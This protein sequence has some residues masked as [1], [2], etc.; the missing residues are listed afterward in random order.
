MSGQA[1]AQIARGGPDQILAMS[2]HEG[3]MAVGARKRVIPVGAKVG[4]ESPAVVLWPMSGP[5]DDSVALVALIRGLPKGARWS[6]V[7]EKV[8]ELGSA[9]AVL[10]SRP[11]VTETTRE[12]PEET[13]RP[14]EGCRR[15][16]HKANKEESKCRIG[17]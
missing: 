1:M 14:S 2:A 11:A 7:T 17:L 9:S 10:E 6:Q 15:W 3:R 4:R 8:L 12:S 13:P 5:T 16:P